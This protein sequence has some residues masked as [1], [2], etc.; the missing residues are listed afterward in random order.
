MHTWKLHLPYLREVMKINDSDHGS[1]ACRNGASAGLSVVNRTPVTSELKWEVFR[2]LYTCLHWEVK[3]MKVPCFNIRKR[4][5]GFHWDPFL[6]AVPIPSHC[7]DPKF[8]FLASFNIYQS[9]KIRVWLADEAVSVSRAKAR[10]TAPCRCLGGSFQRLLL[11]WRQDSW[12]CCR[13][14]FH[15][16][17]WSLLERDESTGFWW[18]LRERI[19]HT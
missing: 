6:L 3:A 16:S 5:V 9:C 4:L 10:D 18:A 14:T 2:F 15:E 8:H 12:L 13:K 19:R 1:W 11:W 7:C 17:L